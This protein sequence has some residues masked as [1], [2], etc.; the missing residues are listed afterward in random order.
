VLEKQ[1]R[2]SLVE[3]PQVLQV[4]VQGTHFFNVESE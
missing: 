3:V 1:E 4:F 2:Q